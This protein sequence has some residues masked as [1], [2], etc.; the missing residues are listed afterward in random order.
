MKNTVVVID[1]RSAIAEQFL[2]EL[3]HL[4]LELLK[5]KQEKNPTFSVIIA[6]KSKGLI[7]M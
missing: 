3:Q 5:M 6:E 7:H 1:N 4:A 2:S